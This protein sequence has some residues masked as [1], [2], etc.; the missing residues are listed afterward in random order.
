MIVVN[1]PAYE[2]LRSYHDARIRNAR[3][4]TRRRLGDALKGAGFGVAFITYWNSLLFPLMVLRRRIFPPA[5][6]ES[7]VRPYSPAL[8][9]VFRSVLLVE[10]LVMRS[11]LRFPWGGSVLAI[12]VKNG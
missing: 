8:D 3:R 5:E 6:G 7:D 12:G 2:W 1:V 9:L 10:R 4:Y 11:G